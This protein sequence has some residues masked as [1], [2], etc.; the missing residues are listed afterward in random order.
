MGA[1]DDLVERLTARL[2]VD[3]E[4][5]MDVANELRAHLIDSAEE[6]RR[7]GLDEAGAAQQA[8][9][10]LGDEGA[11]SEQLWQANRGRIRVRRAAKWAARVTLV[12]AAVLVILAVWLSVWMPW[13]FPL[14]HLSA[15]AR[16]LF[17]GDPSARTRVQK[18]KSISDRWP[19]NPVYYA[20]YISHYLIDG[21]VTRG[22]KN[23]APAVVSEV[24]AEL[25]KG[26]RL[27]PDNAFYNVMKAAI[28]IN[29]SSSAREDP[30]RTY[31]RVQ[32][33]ASGPIAVNCF[34]AEISDPEMFARGLEELKRAAV[35][36]R[37]SH[38]VVDM[39]EERL[40]PL[41]QPRRLTEYLQRL[42]FQMRSCLLPPLHEMRS[43]TQSALGHA[44]DLAKRGQRQQAVEL[45]GIVKAVSV[46]AGA[47]A[48]TLMDLLLARSIY[49]EAL[50]HSVHVFE[51]LGLAEQAR[52]AREQLS[53][54]EEF[55]ESIRG[56]PRVD[57]DEQFRH[58]GLCHVTLSPSL[59]GWVPQF[60]PLRS[61]EYALL[62]QAALIVLLVV[63]VL[64]AL[65]AGG[66]SL[67]SL[68]RGRGQDDGPKLM[69]VGWRRLGRICLL[70]I[71]LPVGLYAFYAH[72]TSL[73]GRGY[74]LL[75]AFD[76]VGLEL[77]VV[78]AAALALLLGLSY[79]ALRR[80]CEEAGMAVPAPGRLRSRR[81][82]LVSGAVIAAGVLG[83]VV[84]WDLGWF[85]P[86]G[87]SWG[88]WGPGIW[89]SLLVGAHLLAWGV[90]DLTRLRLLRG[91]L[92]HFRRTLFRSLVPILAA[93]VIV[94]GAICGL[95]LSRLEAGAMTHVKGRASLDF[96]NE[97]RH[98]DYLRLQQR[99]QH[100]RQA[101]LTETPGPRVPPATEPVGSP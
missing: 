23:R 94:V 11:L 69:F 51:E 56:G 63:V 29:A 46:K 34:S 82:F 15:E 38:H 5:R 87:L 70:A 64:L 17:D 9:K 90:Y 41:G 71:I 48:E 26:V 96:T 45:L 37:Y 91:E 98:S 42:V 77:F 66:V 65:A 53:L 95:S 40:E 35:K 97:I 88:A 84:G 18:A 28:L 50:G 68:V 33:K 99:F 85:R 19:K 30:D 8:V 59:P 14:R 21:E 47:E 2:R 32:K 78:G 27:D 75:F 57:K 62:E 43:M 79:S 60:E 61:A 16:F 73:S 36:A 101:L 80:R 4:L 7:A 92:A 93:A 49:V 22:L 67:I 72:A 76:K 44:L 3:P 74:G 100:Q 6:F 12:P 86:K 31:P 89:L 20:N 81:A 52:H 13:R 55:W 24:L 1:F 83:Y 10:A 58:A 39:L 54:E 25:E